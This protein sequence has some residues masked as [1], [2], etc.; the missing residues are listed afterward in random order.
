M[1]DNTGIGNVQGRI[2][3]GNNNLLSVYWKMS[4]ITS[5]YRQLLS[6]YGSSGNEQ[7]VIGTEGMSVKNY[8]VG[9]GGTYIG[10][11]KSQ[12]YLGLNN[13]ID[14]YTIDTVESSF[15]NTRQMSIQYN[16][17]EECLEFLAS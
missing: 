15:V 11:S 1:G 10:P 14:F 4:S 8:L 17:D 6:F 5:Y 3:G 12:Y 13:G 7:F 2:G 16:G 9:L